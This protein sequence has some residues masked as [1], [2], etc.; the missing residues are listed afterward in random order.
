MKKFVVCLFGML[1]AGGV[2]A[3]TFFSLE[4]VPAALNVTLRRHQ[5]I[6]LKLEENCSTGYAWSASYDARQCSVSI[7]HKQP[8]FSGEN[9]SGGY[10]KI[11]IEPLQGDSFVVTLHY[12]D[13]SNRNALPAKTLKVNGIVSQMGVAAP[14]HPTQSA[15]I[16]QQNVSPQPVASTPIPVLMDDQSFRFEAIPAAVQTTL[17]PGQDIDFELEENREQ[18]LIWQIKT[19]DPSI[20]RIEIEHERGGILKRAKAE[21]EVKAI[22]PGSTTIEFTAG[23]G[24]NAKTFRCIV[25]VK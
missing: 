18:N 2:W 11:E 22:R 15:A 23:V 12:I 3:D 21:I 6:D 4:K 16:P 10:A 24:A 13:A 9:G 19:Y 8:E 7:E 1:I 14:S 17:V 20:C 5:D 25:N